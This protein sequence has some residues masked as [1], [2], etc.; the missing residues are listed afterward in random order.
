MTSTST[1]GCHVAK[2]RESTL[3]KEDPIL[4]KAAIK[5]ANA[6]GRGA[7]TLMALVNLQLRKDKTNG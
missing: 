6:Y 2:R 7:K 5:L 1:R 3:D 4:L